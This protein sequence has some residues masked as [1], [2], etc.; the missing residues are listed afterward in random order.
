MTRHAFLT[1]RGSKGLLH[2]VAKAG[3]NAVGHSD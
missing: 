1:M 3:S 2:L